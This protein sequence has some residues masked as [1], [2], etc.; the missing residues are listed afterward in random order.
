MQ[1]TRIVQRFVE[2][3]F[4]RIDYLLMEIGVSRRNGRNHSYKLEPYVD[5]MSAIRI[6]RQPLLTG[7]FL[8]VTVPVFFSRSHGFFL[9]SNGFDREEISRSIYLRLV[10]IRPESISNPISPRVAILV[11]EKRD[12]HRTNVASS[13]RVDSI[14]PRGKPFS[15]PLP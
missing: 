12:C 9:R 11:F 1:R 2:S 6:I 3:K 10:S 7:A 4:L 14:R 5:H 15:A 13:S 8:E